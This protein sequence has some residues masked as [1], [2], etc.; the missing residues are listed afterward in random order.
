MTDLIP[1]TALGTAAAETTRIGQY[2]LHEN[3]GL[4]LASLSCA[5]DVKPFGLALPEPGKMTQDPH[6]RSAIWMGQG[7]WLI[8][9]QDQ[10]E[11]DFAHSLGEELGPKVAAKITEQTDAWVAFDIK[12]TSEGDIQAVLERLV[13]LPFSATGPGCAVRTLV[14]HLSVFILRPNLHQITFLGLRSYAESLHHVLEASLR[15]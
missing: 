11:N 4:A 9:A 8:A 10:A 12:A 1:I 6:G 15:K 7:L 14:H 13:N 3:T 5:D 2:E